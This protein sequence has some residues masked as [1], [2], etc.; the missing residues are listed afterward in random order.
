MN[1]GLFWELL[2]SPVI[3]NLFLLAA[4]IV[5]VLGSYILYLQ[6]RRATRRAIRRALKTELEAMTPIENWD[7]ENIPAQKIGSTFVYQQNAKDLGLLTDREIDLV[8]DL[9]TQLDIVQSLIDSNSETNLAVGL[10]AN[11]VDRGR[12]YRESVIKSRLNFL[13]AWRWETI[14]VLK[15]K[16]GEDHRDPE[17]MDLSLKEGDQISK[18]HP[19]IDQFGER[20]E[21]RGYIESIDDD[22]FQFTKKGEEQLLSK[23]EK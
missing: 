18:E 4:A 12:E 10:K 6:K 7:G 11:A 17:L 21:E 5:G 9:Y 1:W 16:L 2:G 13:F 8:T 14:Q 19:F 23:V 22:R 15:K 20:L 3:G